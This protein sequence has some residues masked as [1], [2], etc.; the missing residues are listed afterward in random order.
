MRV[1]KPS[2]AEFASWRYA[3]RFGHRRRMAMLYG[4]IGT[5][6][7]A[8][9]LIVGLRA[10]LSVGM[11][12][13]GY[14]FAGT[15]LRRDPAARVALIPRFVDESIPVNR[16]DLRQLRLLQQR[17]TEAWLLSLEHGFNMP[18]AQ[19]TD[20]EGVTALALLL[21]VI[22][23]FGARKR[24]CTDAL[25]LLESDPNPMAQVERAA[26]RN[27]YLHALP[28]PVRLALE[29]SAHE[30]A[31]RATAVGELALLELAWRDAEEIAAIADNLLIPNEIHET[32]LRVKRRS[33]RAQDGQGT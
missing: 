18:Y 17:R 16:R 27:A 32:W 33:A 13:Y 28:R 29:M 15:S 11:L 25:A 3:D 31:E 23:R 20:Y 24:D 2:R 21:P 4:A 8:G 26:T 12:G 30:D 14:L 10:G 6:A 9:S 5:V 22:N 1:G 19:L 7:A